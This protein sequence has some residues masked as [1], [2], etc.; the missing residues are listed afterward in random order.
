MQA[1]WHINSNPAKP[2]GYVAT[3]VTFKGK[4]GTTL[5]DLKY[6]AGKLI[7]M[8][9]SDDEISVYDGRVDFFG[10]LVV[11]AEAAGKTEEMEI[12]VK[13]Q[14]C[15]DKKCLLPTTVKLSGKLPV[16]KENEAVRAINQKLFS[17][18]PQ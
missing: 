5:K 13:Y 8:Q 15:D 11:P 12:V 16:A 6:P 1:G 7:R 3:E 17:A 4:Q 18:A 2:E 14:A 10:K 9:N